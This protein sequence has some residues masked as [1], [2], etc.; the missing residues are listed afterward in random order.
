[1]KAGLDGGGPHRPISRVLYPFHEIRRG[2]DGDHLSSLPICIG[3]RRWRDGVAAVVQQPTRGRAGRPLSLYSALL[4]V[5]FDR[6]C[7]TADGRTLLPSDFTLASTHIKAVCFCATFR[8]PERRSAVP[9]AWA[10]PSTL[11]R[12]A[13]TFLPGAR[14]RR[15]GHPVCT[16]L[17][18]AL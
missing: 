1:M 7:V 5:G 13:R 17:R 15:G 9:E 14:E 2:Q 12:G 3:T 11:P 10:L 18:L 16:A 4:Q 6:R 8:P